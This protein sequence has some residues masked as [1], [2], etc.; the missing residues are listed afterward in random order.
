MELDVI[1]PTYN[2]QDLLKLTLESLFTAEIPSGLKVR[3]TVVDNNSKDATQPVVE[4]YQEKFAG[5]LRYQFEPQQGRSHALN[6]GVASTNGD[7]VGMVDDDEKIDESWYKTIF[8]AFKLENVDFIGGP[9]VPNWSIP[10][11]EW[12]P[13]EYRGVI[14]WV[15]GGDQ[16]VP[17][18]ETYPGMLM[19]GNAVIKR[20]LLQQVGPYSTSL[21]RTAKRLLSCEDEDMYRR[22]LEVGARGFYRPD[23][24]IYHHIPSDRLTKSYYRRWCFWRGVSLGVLGRTKPAPS[25]QLFGVPRWLYRKGVVGAFKAIAAP[26]NRHKSPS[27]KFA[28]EL[29]MFDLAGFFCG[30]HFYGGS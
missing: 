9:Y 16:V 8:E 24:I 12:L 20:T 19:G 22:L 10:P 13:Q 5:R 15:N 4:G 1:I 21:G 27:K 11:P 25:T 23:L 26:L 14:G 17:F 7:I 30:R 2:R 6:A 28:D 18:D 3:V 29:A